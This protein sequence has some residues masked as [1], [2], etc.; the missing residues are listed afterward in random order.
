MN[1]VAYQNRLKI[2]MFRLILFLPTLDMSLAQN[3]KYHPPEDVFKI[4]EEIQ[5]LRFKIYKISNMSYSEIHSDVIFKTEIKSSKI[6][7]KKYNN[8]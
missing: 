2:E 6:N 8:E 3:T 7:Y 5:N 1:Y 4:L